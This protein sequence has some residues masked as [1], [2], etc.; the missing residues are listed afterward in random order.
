MNKYEMTMAE[1]IEVAKIETI[2]NRERQGCVTGYCNDCKYFG[3]HYCSSTKKAEALYDE[4]CRIVGEDEIVIKKSEHKALLLEQKRLKEMVD[5]IPCGYVKIADDEMVIKKSEYESL[6]K[7]KNDYKQRFESSDKRFEQLV[8]TS[9]EALEKAQK[10]WE[11]KCK[12]IG[13]VASKETAREILQELYMY[14]T[15]DYLC[16]LR[17]CNKDHKSAGLVARLAKE[18]GIELEKDL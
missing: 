4:G 17:N 8:R 9:V 5:R 11:N 7:D 13:D 14:F 15:E 3:R 18:K 1:M 16:G 6:K 2:I 10:H 12:E